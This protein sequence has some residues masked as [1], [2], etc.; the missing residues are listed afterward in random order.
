MLVA[1]YEYLNEH[2]NIYS[3]RAK[4]HLPIMS[5]RKTIKYIT[6]N[7]CSISRFGDGELSIM[8]GK[9]NLT[10]QRQD[11]EL[12]KSI[13]NVLTSNNKNDNLLIC[14]PL[15]L[16]TDF[17]YTKSAK[18]FWRFWAKTTQHIIVPE[19]LSAMGG[20]Y[21]FGNSLFTRP[22]MDYKFKFFC[23]RKFKRIEKIWINRDILIV[24]GEHSR[25]G[26]NNNLF[27]RAKSIKRILAPAENAF[28]FYSSIV[29][30]IR[31]FHTNELILLA[32]GP[33]ATVLSANLASPTCQIIDIG[34]VDIEYEWFLKKSKTKIP[35]YG[36][37]THEAENSQN[38]ID[39]N[40]EK[41]NSQIIFNITRG[42]I[43]AYD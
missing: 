22:Y 32:L 19:I 28:S 42:N 40:D 21:T 24:E 25:L 13:K 26:I 37:Y 38:F 36:K 9:S 35:I 18:K 11:D 17:G 1:I 31:R 29:E 16:N 39:C 2:I 23:K 33:T 10:F 41:Y 8:S 12:A 14:M 7:N 6:K 5:S 4:N 34:H 43:C 20:N 30:A 3:I 15:T 27:D